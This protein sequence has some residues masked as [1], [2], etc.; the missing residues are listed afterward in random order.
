MLSDRIGSRL[1]T[2]IG[3]G[4]LAVGLFSLS[5]LGPL[6]P[7]TDVILALSITGL[8]TGIFI[9]PNSS[10]LMGAAPVDQRGV[11]AGILATARLVGMVLGVGLAGAILT[12]VLARAETLR[13]SL[14]LFD[15]VRAGFVVASSVA[16]LGVLV[17]AIRETPLGRERNLERSLTAGKE[18]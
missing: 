1:P 17:S 4:I 2:T 12:T 18:R 16:V 10:A 15:G 8:G 14:A 13:R 11:A 6:S 7:L 9:S 5:R 3:M